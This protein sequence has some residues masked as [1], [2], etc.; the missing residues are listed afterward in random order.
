MNWITRCPECATVYQLAP[1]QI[2]AAKGWVR[3]GQC[4]HAFD[5]TGLIL[6]WAGRAHAEPAAS[7][8]GIMFDDVDAA[9]RLDVDA[10]LHRKELANHPDHDKASDDL[11]AFEK[12]LSSFQPEIE[13]AIDQLSVE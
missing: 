4:H 1:E 12:A 8:A 2:D 7:K 6:A 5:S 11:N 10:L 3:C 13:K 9:Q